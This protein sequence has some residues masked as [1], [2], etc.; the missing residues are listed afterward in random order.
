MHTRTPAPVEPPHAH[1]RVTGRGQ[2][3]GSVAAGAP[4]ELQAGVG[5]DITAHIRRSL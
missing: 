3:T 4:S 2:R 1:S 5:P